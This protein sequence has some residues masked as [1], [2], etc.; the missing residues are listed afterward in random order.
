MKRFF[1]LIELLVVI[2]IIAILASML[3]PALSKAREKARAITCISRHK[4][5]LTSQLLYANDHNDM[6]AMFSRPDPAMTVKYA[7]TWVG[8]LINFN[9]APD[10]L[11][12]FCCPIRD[13]LAY[14]L[15]GNQIERCFA[16]FSFE[17][18]RAANQTLYMKRS[19]EST[20]I[21][22]NF[23]NYS[24][25]LG[26]M[27]NTSNNI[28]LIDNGTVG[29]GPVPYFRAA[30]TYYYFPYAYHSGQIAMAFADGHAG[31]MRGHALK[32][33]V[34]TVNSDY[35]YNGNMLWFIGIGNHYTD[36]NNIYP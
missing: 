23:S 18:V 12:I 17:E 6:I 11:K 31:L 8:V 14:Q 27:T 4:N 34:K 28:V 22:G 9:Y 21:P 32:A 1:T 13:D 5:A 24:Y 33:L 7:N 2:A 15:N 35:N 26:A 29:D 10:N 25:N 30:R 36:G 16:M 20:P 19:V 3:L